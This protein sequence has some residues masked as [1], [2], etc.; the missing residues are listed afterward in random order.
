MPKV[1]A[2]SVEE[3]LPEKAI[4]VFAVRENCKS[5]TCPAA[6]LHLSVVER[7]L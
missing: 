3:I 7:I 4:V 1:E 2:L 6:S 5:Q